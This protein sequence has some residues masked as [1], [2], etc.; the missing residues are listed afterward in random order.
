[1]Q[2]DFDAVIDRRTTSSVKWHRSDGRDDEILPLWIA[3]M[4]F[5][6]PDPVARALA[7]RAGH[8]V[9]GYTEA[10][11]SYFEAAAG[12]MRDRQGWQVSPDWILPSDGV[13]RDL[14]MLVRNMV[15]PGEKVLIQPPIYH[16]FFAAI[17]DNRAEV[18]EN[19]LIADHGRYTMDFEDLERKLS[20]G[21]VKLAL[22][23]SPHNP[24]G[25]VWTADEL[26]TF[27]SICRTHGV[28]VVVDEIFGDLVYPSNQFVP[29]Q[30]VSRDILPRTI[31]CTSP[32]KTFNLA[33]LRF[34]NLIIADEASRLD[35]KRWRAETGAFGVNIFGLAA[36]ES[37]YRAGGEWFDQM[38]AYL[39][40]NLSLIRD[41]V[42][43]RIPNVRLIEPEGTF[44]AWLDF[45]GMGLSSPELSRLIRETARLHLI[46]GPVFGTGG[47]GF[48]RLNFACPRSRLLEALTRLETVV[49]KS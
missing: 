29:F 8:P 6:S 35:V 14:Y 24:V 18:V 12:W 23:C 45:R 3:D 37:A 41:S 9:Y 39:A 27:A 25:R 38:L 33:G 20:S 11:A 48:E 46:D 1:M 40:G 32:G 42:S 47:E 31:I 26:E 7:D 34:S 30:T 44:L 15:A 5:P 16:P 22:L 2:Y 4:D 36:G 17:R 49:Q 10:S 21:P 13:V 28:R 19:P 43:N